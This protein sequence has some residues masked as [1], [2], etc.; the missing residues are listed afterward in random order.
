MEVSMPRKEAHA[1]LPTNY[2]LAVRRLHGLHRRLCQNPTTLQE[3][4]KIIQD[5]IKKGIVQLVE[6]LVEPHDCE[7]ERM[8]H[9]LPHHAVVRQSR[10]TTKVRVVYDAS[11]HST[12]PSLNDCLHAGPKFNQ[13]TLLRF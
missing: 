8:L 9:Y 2:A 12:E 4:D 6:P 3:Y 5:Q 13:K 10:E 1:P 11:A 7:N